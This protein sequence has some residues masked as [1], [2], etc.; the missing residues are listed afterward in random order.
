MEGQMKI[1]Q[2]PLTENGCYKSGKKITVKG[3][4]LHSVGCNQ[5]SA[6]VFIKNWNKA[7]IKKCV[8]AF[9]EPDAI[10]Q[11]L[12]WTM[13]GWHAG[14]KA[15]DSYIGVEMT[16]PGTI[17][18]TGG[19]KWTDTDPEATKKHV[20]ATY[21][22]AVELFT[23]LCKEFKLDPITAIISHSE[24][25]KKG[26]ASNHGD[27]EHVWR[28]FGLTIDRFKH[29]VKDSM[30]KYYKVAE[31][32][33]IEL[34]PM[35]MRAELT[36]KPNRKNYV[37]GNFFDKVTTIGWLASEGK[38]LEDRMNH[39]KDKGKYDYPKGTVIV[40]KDRTVF[41]GLKTDKEMDSVRDKIWFC[42]QG[43]NLFPIY[44]KKEGFP[45]DVARSCNRLSMGYRKKDNKILVT[46]RPGSN[47][48]RAA[49][50]LK[51]LE[52]DTGICLDSGRSAEMVVDGIKLYKAKNT[53][54]NIIWWEG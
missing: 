21:S 42:C 31:T 54:T 40:F 7:G 35:D 10:Y 28:K 23:H 53:L 1:I 20:L 8:H 22:T 19:D 46:M 2:S 3:L 43:F 48:D 5:P 36:R 25:Y 12:P 41:A 50:T 29:D 26:I 44:L 52:C 38:I 27:P 39:L 24:G 51:N 4:M 34:D 47:A 33:I 17:K 11:C 37:N 16:E 14:G 30:W 49:Q 32:D 9:I 18:Y 13:R 6:Q 15:N 45:D